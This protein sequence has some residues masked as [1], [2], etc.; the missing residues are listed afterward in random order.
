VGLR[1][2]PRLQKILELVTP[3]T[4]PRIRTKAFKYLTDNFIDRYSK[5][6]KPTEI[7]IAF[8]PCMRKYVY[9]KPTECYTNP[10]CM[11]MNFNVIRQNLL[12]CAVQFG[13]Q[14]NPSHDKLLKSL[15]DHPPRNINKA[16]EIFEYLASQQGNFTP[17]D[18]K[19]LGDLN[20]IPVE[21]KTKPNAI[22]LTN[23]HSCFLTPVENGYV[24]CYIYIS[25]WFY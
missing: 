5:D 25:S 8:L 10:E 3:P 2:Y 7:N 18:W 16:K 19:I 23:P 20:F 11:I 13:I 24:L 21:D 4:D 17:S 9:A 1:E 22:N 12:Y 15:V 14:S 6:Y